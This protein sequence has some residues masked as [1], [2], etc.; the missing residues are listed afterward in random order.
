MLQKASPVFRLASSVL[1]V[2]SVAARLIS[3]LHPPP[4]TSR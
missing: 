3:H 2:A 1:R 4:T